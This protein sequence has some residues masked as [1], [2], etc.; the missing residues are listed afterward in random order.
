MKSLLRGIVKIGKIKIKDG[1]EIDL[2]KFLEETKLDAVFDQ[3]EEHLNREDI[4]RLKL[5]E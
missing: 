4:T 1:V 3:L 5:T 2:K